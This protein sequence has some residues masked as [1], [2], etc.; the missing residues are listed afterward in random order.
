MLQVKRRWFQSWWQFLD[1]CLRIEHTVLRYKSDL[2][3]NVEATMTL[4]QI[5]NFV[6]VVWGAV[7]ITGKYIL[8]QFNL[9]C[10]NWLT[11]FSYLKMNKK[12]FDILSPFFRIFAG[13]RKKSLTFIWKYIHTINASCAALHSCNRIMIF[14]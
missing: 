10:I 7:I 14:R 6:L 13:F 5:C 9:N 8:S 12:L 11:W 4:I 3:T 2:R 1:T